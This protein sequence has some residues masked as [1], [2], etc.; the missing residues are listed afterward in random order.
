MLKQGLVAGIAKGWRGFVWMMKIVVPV[1]FFTAMLSWSGWMERL[2][3]RDPPVMG[4]LSFAG[5][6]RPSAAHWQC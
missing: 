1:S 2:D 3:F 6:C 5:Y 4:F